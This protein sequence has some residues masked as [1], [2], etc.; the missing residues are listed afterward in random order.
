MTERGTSQIISLHYHVLFFREI[1]AF[2]QH[3]SCLTN[4][5]LSLNANTIADASKTQSKYVHVTRVSFRVSV[6]CNYHAKNHIGA[7]VMFVRV[8]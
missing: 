2:I 8:D 6:R 7:L 5:D 4:D 3:L 1:N